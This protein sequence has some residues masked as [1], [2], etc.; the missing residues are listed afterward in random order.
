[1]YQTKSNNQPQAQVCETCK[2]MKV[3]GACRCPKQQKMPAW[4][5][6]TLR[7]QALNQ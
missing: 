6:K 4:M 3:N 5:A 2:T 7:R 1:M